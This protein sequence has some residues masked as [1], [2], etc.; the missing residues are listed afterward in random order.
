MCPL[1]GLGID[2]VFHGTAHIEIE[3]PKMA[4]RNKFKLSHDSDVYED[5]ESDPPNES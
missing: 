1:C 2:G 3:K 4:N 5:T